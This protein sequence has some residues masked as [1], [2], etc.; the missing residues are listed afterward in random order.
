MMKFLR[1]FTPAE[2]FFGAGAVLI[3]EY[4]R[5]ADLETDVH[6][7]AVSPS[8][9]RGHLEVLARLGNV[10]PLEK[11]AAGRTRDFS[12]AAVVLTADDG[13]EDLLTNALPALEHFGLPATFFIST[14]A[15]DSPCEFWWDELE[16]IFLLTPRLPAR[17]ELTAGG[18]PLCF[19]LAPDQ[20]LGEAEMLRHRRWRAWEAPPTRRH[21]L[22]LYVQER[23]RPLSGRRMNELLD[24]LRR[25]AA[26]PAS[27]RR[28]HRALSTE[29]LKGLAAGSGI[30]LGSHTVTH[31]MMSQLS[32]E[33]QLE[34]L[35]SS[36]RFLEETTRKSV[37]LFG[38][39]YGYAEDYSAETVRL[40][41]KAGYRK[42]CTS[43]PGIVTRDTNPF[44]LPRVLV[45]DCGAGT[46]EK[47]LARW[48]KGPVADR[49]AAK[50]GF[51]K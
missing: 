8:N 15:I 5:I 2:F 19:D 26:I 48:L 27:G 14:A 33:E 46:F 11:A 37:T 16:R 43:I 32:A 45:R 34:E 39:P 9:F 35:R 6:G 30:S 4:H 17:L 18:V 24:A 51:I 47:N 40:V 21:E 23:M 29:Q 38:Y 12:S 3:L 20:T 50:E 36:R 22:Y 7:L 41:K 28:T 42:A 13:Y 10:M 44:E 49:A 31:P 1:R 25:W